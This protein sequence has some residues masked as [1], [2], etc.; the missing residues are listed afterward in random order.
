SFRP[1]GPILAIAGASGPVT[2][3]N[4]ADGTL[5]APLAD[6]SGPVAFSRDGSLIAT[7]AAR[8]EIALWDAE[9]GKL[10][11]TMQG[12]STGELRGIE[13][14]HAGKFLASFGTDGFVV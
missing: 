5:A 7:N 14:S 3:W 1:G 12:H 8:Q 2:L 13:F 10:R 6:T 9:T 11:R 4:A